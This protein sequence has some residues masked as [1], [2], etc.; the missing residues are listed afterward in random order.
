MKRH[1]K[2]PF[3]IFQEKEYSYEYMNEQ[4]NKFAHAAQK[5]GLK[6]GDNV[7]MLMHNEPDYIWTY[8]GMVRLTLMIIMVFFKWITLNHFKLHFIF[9]FKQHF[10]CKK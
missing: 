10:E 7:A 8:L 3:I 1:P 9:F 6:R 2:K 5:I 4:M